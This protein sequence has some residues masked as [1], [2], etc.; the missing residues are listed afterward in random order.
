MQIIVRNIDNV[1]IW[2]TDD[3]NV[4]VIHNNGNLIISGEVVARSVNANNYYLVSLPNE[5]LPTPFYV[6]YQKWIDETFWFTEGYLRW[7][8]NTRNCINAVK[9]EYIDKSLDL[10]YDPEMRLAFEGYAYELSLVEGQQYIEPSWNFPTPPDETSPYY[11]P[12]SYG[13]NY[14]E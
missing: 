6:G 14:I 12:C 3:P 11:P 7:L 8:S 5:V 10:S 13:N 4:T 2:G 1:I 9:T